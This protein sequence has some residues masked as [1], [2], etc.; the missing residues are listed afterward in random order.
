MAPFY[1]ERTVRIEE[2]YPDLEIGEGAPGLGLVHALL[3]GRET[4]SHVGAHLGFFLGEVVFF[5]D[6]MREVGQT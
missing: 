5:P 2:E 3:P 4:R 1:G 6:V